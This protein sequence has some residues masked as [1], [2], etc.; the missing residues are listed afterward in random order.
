MRIVHGSNRY[1]SERGYLEELSIEHDERVST[2]DP[3]E[4]LFIA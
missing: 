4:V 2:R 3:E 1:N